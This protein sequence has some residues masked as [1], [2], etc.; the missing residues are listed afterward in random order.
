MTYSFNSLDSIIPT[1]LNLVHFIAS[2]QSQDFIKDVI[3]GSSQNTFQ[4]LNSSKESTFELISYLTKRTLGRV[5]PTGMSGDSEKLVLEL[6]EQNISR[7]LPSPLFIPQ[8]K[9]GSA[10]TGAFFNSG[11][12][13]PTKFYSFSTL[14]V[15]DDWLRDYIR[16][17]A[18][19]VTH[20]EPSNKN[21]GILQR[22]V[23]VDYPILIQIRDPRAI[24]I[25][26][27][28]H[29][30]KYKKQFHP[31]LSRNVQFFD[32]LNSPELFFPVF[33]QQIQWIE[34]WIGAQNKLNIKII[35]YE[36][37]VSD[38]KKAQE[39]LLGF[40]SIEDKHFNIDDFDYATKNGD[41][42]FRRGKPLEHLEIWPKNSLTLLNQSIPGEWFDRFKWRK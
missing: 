33:Q 10:L 23:G 38:F 11:L 12:N 7:N 21:V 32:F 42:H 2:L 19:H 24:V 31:I 35:T 15:I 17:G 40:M 39:T 22:V 37:V 25:S 26:L 13:L 9:S 18:C 29:F 1:P 41:M 20:L 27:F 4:L 36:E 34:G 5:A 8:N 16:G 14:Y 6:I 28:Y 3:G 30:S